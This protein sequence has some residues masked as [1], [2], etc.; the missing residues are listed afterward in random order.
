MRYLIYKTSTL[1]NPLTVHKRLL[2]IF[3][4]SIYLIATAQGQPPGRA[5]RAVRAQMDRQFIAQRAIDLIPI[6]YQGHI[7]LHRHAYTVVLKN[8]TTYT[9]KTKMQLNNGR[10][11][12][13]YR[14]NGGF[15]RFF[16]KDTKEIYII[17]RQGDTMVGRPTTGDTSWIFQVSKDKINTFSVVPEW[18]TTY[19]SYVQKD[20]LTRP[21][22]I[23][24][25]NIIQMVQDNPKALKNAKKNRLM[26]AI[27]IYNGKY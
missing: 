18:E 6:T 19:I 13:R 1:T 22:K 14:E 26:K 16:P 23:N 24:Q 12:L 5:M 9:G 27:L 8:G 4:L 3:S 7:P 15:K 11:Y 17:R 20:T 25:D 2:L 10:S 21:V